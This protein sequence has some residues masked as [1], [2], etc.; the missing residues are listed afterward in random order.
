MFERGLS[1]LRMLQNRSEDEKL[2]VFLIEKALSKIPEGK[3]EIL[4][5]IDLRGFSLQNADLNFI[6]FLVMYQLQWTNW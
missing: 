2:S 6:P 3:D 1:K 4:A 5:I